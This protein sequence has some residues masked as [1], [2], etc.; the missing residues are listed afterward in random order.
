MIVGTIIFILIVAVALSIGRAVEHS[1]NRILK[2]ED[3]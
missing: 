2:D 3:E 1:V